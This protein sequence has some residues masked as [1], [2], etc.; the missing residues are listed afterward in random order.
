[1]GKWL[2]SEG[3]AFTIVDT[4]GFGSVDTGELSTRVAIFFMVQHTKT[5]GNI[6]MT[7]KYT[8]KP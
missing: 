1:V 3:K 6:P 5:G 7:L 4:P 8:K 2:G